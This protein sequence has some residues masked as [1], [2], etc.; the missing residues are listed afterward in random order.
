M[1]PSIGVP[2]RTVEPDVILHMGSVF[3][4]LYEDGAYQLEVDYSA[5]A[6]PAIALEDAAWAR[7][8]ISVWGGEAPEAT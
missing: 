6:N 8:R 5:E 7:E 1:L 2:L 4:R 3:T